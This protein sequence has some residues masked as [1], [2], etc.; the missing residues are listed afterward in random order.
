M[1]FLIKSEIHR[2]QMFSSLHEEVPREASFK[3]PELDH[4]LTVI[5]H[6]AILSLLASAQKSSQQR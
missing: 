6:S 4:C 3:I 1:R 5:V 2:I